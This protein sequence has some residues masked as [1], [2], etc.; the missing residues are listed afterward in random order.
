MT[1]TTT[2]YTINTLPKTKKEIVE[3]LFKAGQIDL[4]EVLELMKEPA[5]SIHPITP[6]QPWQPWNPG[7]GFPW[8]VTYDGYTLATLAKG[9]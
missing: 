6:Q 8:T 7:D 1:T 3:R 5:V 2:N 9:E 4:D